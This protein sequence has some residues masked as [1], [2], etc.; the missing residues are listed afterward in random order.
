MTH[1]GP[2]L[3]I[4]KED[5]RAG[6]EVLSWQTDRRVAVGLATVANLGQK[7]AGEVDLVLSPTTMFAI[8]V[9]L[10]D[11]KQV[12]ED[13]AK[14]GAFRPGGGTLFRTTPQEARIIKRRCTQW[15]NFTDRERPVRS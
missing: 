8:P 9:P 10:L 2:S 11:L 3:K 6:D 15:Q 4:L 12:Y 1:H 7:A 14:V 5:M 13:L